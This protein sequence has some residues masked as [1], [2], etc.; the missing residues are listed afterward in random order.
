M[1]YAINRLTQVMPNIS[2]LIHH[3]MYLGQK[4]FSSISK[5]VD[6]ESRFADPTYDD[7]FKRLF[8]EEGNKG[9]LINVLNS[10]LGFSST[11]AITTHC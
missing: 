2:K 7:T 5:R 4:G 6:H 10:F 3:P 9:L 11:N 1:K 8:G